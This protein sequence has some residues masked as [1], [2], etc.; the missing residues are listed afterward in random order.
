MSSLGYVMSHGMTMHGTLNSSCSVELF[1]NG[2]RKKWISNF[3]PTISN[4]N[5]NQF[6][7]ILKRMVK[8]NL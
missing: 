1:V 6:W 8:I 4:T 5:T 3:T 7:I 2:I